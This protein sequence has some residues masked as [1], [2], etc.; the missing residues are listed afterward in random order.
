MCAALTNYETDCF[1]YNL[2]NTTVCCR[3]A[4]STFPSTIVLY[5]CRAF[6]LAMFECT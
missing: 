4:A 5:V 6:L 1:S 3:L 2:L